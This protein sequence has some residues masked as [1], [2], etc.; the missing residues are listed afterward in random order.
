MTHRAQQIV[1]SIVSE[2]TAN[3]AFGW[4]VYRQRAESLDRG[5]LELPA[6]S[7]DFGIDKPVSELGQTNLNFIDSLLELKVSLIAQ[8]GS[9]VD[10]I[11]DLIEMRRQS[12]IT[13]MTDQTQGLAFVIQTRYGGADEPALSV[14][15]SLF[16][17]VLRTH[18]TVYYR[19]NLAD[20]S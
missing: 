8:R 7:V 15:N 2:L 17:G 16:G 4:T 18:W 6:V 3:T 9:E 19:M 1:D 12:H 13:L 5:E 14:S 11:A 20:P 10:V